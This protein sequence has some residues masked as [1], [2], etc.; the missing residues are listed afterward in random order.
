MG[1]ERRTLRVRVD[2]YTRT[3]LTVIAI[4]LTVLIVGLWAD[5]APSVDRAEAVLRRPKPEKP[6]L[7]TSTQAQIVQVVRAQDRTTAKIAELIA[8]LRSGQVTVKVAD[9]G[10]AKGGPNGPA[11]DGK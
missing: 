9:D 2:G 3:C 10:K 8:L 6:F 11:K 5:H 4:L 1:K 7:D